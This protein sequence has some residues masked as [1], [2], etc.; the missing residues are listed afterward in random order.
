MH[1][2]SF[3]RTIERNCV[4]RWRFLIGEYELDEPA[5]EAVALHRTNSGELEGSS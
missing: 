1:D 5:S 2:G 4:Q 3:D